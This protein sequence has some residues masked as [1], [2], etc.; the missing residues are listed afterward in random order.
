MA[1]DGGPQGRGEID[2]EMR[3]RFGWL[4]YRVLAGIALFGCGFV[5][6][7]DFVMWFLVEGYNPIGQTI[8]ELAAGPHAEIQDTGIVVFAVGTAALTA[9]LILRG[10]G[11][12]L[13]WAVRVA[14]VL[15]GLDVALIALWNEYGDGQPGG[16]VIHRYLVTALYFLTAFLLWFGTSVPP[17]KGD[18]IARFGKIAAGVWV[19]AAPLFYVVPDAVDGLYERGLALVMVGAVAL[20]AIELFGNPKNE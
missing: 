7:T 19:V 2:E 6:L 18:N 20:A 9:G 13:S 8:S 11:T 3:S 15:V 17:A 16:L 1:A 5:L 14:F 12:P 4:P 10:K